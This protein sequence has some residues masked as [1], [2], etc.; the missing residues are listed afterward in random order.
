MKTY[1]SV[2]EW[3]DDEGNPRTGVDRGWTVVIG[4]RN[5][6]V[7]SMERLWYEIK[8]VA[9]LHP[10]LTEKDVNGLCEP[11]ISGGSLRKEVSFG[12]GCDLYLRLNHSLYR[13]EET[14]ESWTLYTADVELSWSSTGRTPS[15]AQ[16]CV[17][18][19]QK[20]TALALDLEASLQE[21]LMAV[22]SPS[23]FPE[24]KK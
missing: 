11:H 9:S 16:A 18:L 2:R 15:Q 14:N 22:E 5:Q 4:R 8:K 12:V 3:K 23:T 10:W 19:Y 1:T 24:G 21:Y 17:N 7:I 13:K 20:F 6:P